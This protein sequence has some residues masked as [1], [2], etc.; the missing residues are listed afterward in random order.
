MEKIKPAGIIAGAPGVGKSA[1]MDRLSVN[2]T[3]ADLEPT[4]Y[5]DA[6]DWPDNY[7]EEV[8]QRAADKDLVLITTN[9][10]VIQALREKGH[11][12]SVV[13]PD[14]SLRDEYRQRYINR[15][16]KPEVVEKILA[17]AHKPNEEIVADFEG[18][19]VLF[20]QSGQCLSDVIDFD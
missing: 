14:E 8:V 16:N 11:S 1:L 12:V 17:H 10:V 4:P 15:G 18:C 20:L 3:V 19:N 7:I 2:L 5:T 9:P 13:C 6:E